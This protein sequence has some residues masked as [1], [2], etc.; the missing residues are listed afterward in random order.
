MD[1]NKVMI[2]GR[3]T[4]DA[5][6]R[7]TPQ[8]T[9]VTTLSIANNK[10]VKRDN[11]WVQEAYY[12]DCTMFGKSGENLNKYLKKGKQVAIEGELQQDRWNDKDTG[13]RRSKVKIN[14]NLLQLLGGTE[15]TSFQDENFDEDGIP[16]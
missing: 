2:I 7:Y 10:K 6:L 5:E 15:T 9:A 16:F 4:K 1:L 14:V 12:F 11:E 3:L 13:A 8:G